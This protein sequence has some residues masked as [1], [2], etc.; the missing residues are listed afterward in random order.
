V[1][2]TVLAP[3]VLWV[4]G[5]L[6]PQHFASQRDLCMLSCAWGIESVIMRAVFTNCAVLKYAWKK[7]FSIKFEP[8]Q[9]TESY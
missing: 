9:A 1:C 8:S 5:Q 2:L 6:R 4:R 3:S 7:P